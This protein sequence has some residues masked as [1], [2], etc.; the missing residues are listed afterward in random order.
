MHIQGE[1][2]MF[3]STAGNWSHKYSILFAQCPNP[4]LFEP[5]FQILNVL[6]V[7]VQYST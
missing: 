7:K 1:I 5:D 4:A 3:N 2:M 6:E